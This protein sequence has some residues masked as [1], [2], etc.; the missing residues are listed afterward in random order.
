MAAL[1]DT[2]GLTKTFGSVRALDGLDLRVDEG[3]VHGFLGP[4]GAGK[5]TTLRIILGLTRKTAGTISVLGK[6]PWRDAVAIHTGVGYVPGDVTLWPNLS[7]GETID[8]LTALHGGAD[9]TLRAQLISDFELDP[10]KKGRSYSKGNRQKVALIA[11]LARR[12][13]LYIFDEP[14]S[15]LD[16][17]MESVFRSHV[18][19][20]R[21][22][23]ATV[24]LSSHILSEVEQ[25]C[26]RVTIIRAGVAVE[27]GSLKE[28][29]HLTS[30]A[31][32][33]TTDLDVEVV[34]ALPGVLHARRL[35]GVLTFDVETDASG[36]V[37]SELTKH[38]I[39]AI[40]ITPPSLEELF[41]RHYGDPAAT[42]KAL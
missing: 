41:L 28:M 9:P 15:G 35:D 34:A 4:N 29:R 5:S 10:R 8:F 12:A 30:S 39:D 22:E 25:L 40:T 7:G 38:R 33:V 19:R 17:V 13:S 24:L 11:A 16:P 18:A 21:A 37:L 14:T 2:V 42:A 6:D 23:G 32:T 31:F 1:V 27:R 26:D 3:E 36:R 20:I